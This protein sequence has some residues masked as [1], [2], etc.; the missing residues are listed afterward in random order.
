MDEEDLETVN[1]EKSILVLT[2]QIANNLEISHDGQMNS[3]YTCLPSALVIFQFCISL[4]KEVSQ[5][6]GKYEDRY[7]V[8]AWSPPITAI[9]AIVTTSGLHFLHIVPAVTSPASS[10]ETIGCPTKADGVVQLCPL[11]ASWTFQDRFSPRASE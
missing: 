2:G 5:V 9:I 6:K 10:R 4:C 3:F 11:H 7:L 8:I 1:W